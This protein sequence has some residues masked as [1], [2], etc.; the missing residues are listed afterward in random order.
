MALEV[1][2]GEALGEV[3]LVGELDLSTVP[4]AEQELR[5]A[6]SEA[7]RLTVNLSELEF[8]DSG[9]VRLILHLLTEQRAKGG[10]LVLE[11]PT[12]TV[13]RLFDLLELEANG[14]VILPG[15]SGEGGMR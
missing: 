9:G 6:A 12:T 1:R 7:L 14:V 5:A 2:R 11:A 10:D 4:I 3:R 8:M 13:R 15:A